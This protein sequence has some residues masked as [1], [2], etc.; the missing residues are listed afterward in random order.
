LPIQNPKDRGKNCLHNV[1]YDDGD[2]DIIK[3]TSVHNIN[4]EHVSACCHLNGREN[5]SA[6]GVAR[7]KIKI[8]TCN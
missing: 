6:C 1:V 7:R 8:K 2:D 4:S 5:A 3:F